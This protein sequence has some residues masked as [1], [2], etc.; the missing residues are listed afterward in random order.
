MLLVAIHDM[1]Y[2]DQVDRFRVLV[3]FVQLY[4]V[5]VSPKVKHDFH[6]VLD[7]FAEGCLGGSGGPSLRDALACESL[8]RPPAHGHVHFAKL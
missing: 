4:D 3:D 2:K 1:A 5:L 6:L 8:S 7:V